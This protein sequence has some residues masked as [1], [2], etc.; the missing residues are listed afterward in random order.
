MMIVMARSHG[1]ATQ[2]KTRQ[3]AESVQRFNATKT[4][5]GISKYATAAAPSD[6]SASGVANQQHLQKMRVTQAH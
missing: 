6:R 5:D 2:A 3:P 4:H 1:S